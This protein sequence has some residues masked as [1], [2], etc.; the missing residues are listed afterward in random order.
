MRNGKEEPLALREDASLNA[1]GELNGSIEAPMVFVGYGLSIP[2]A[3]WDDLAGL[4]LRGKIAVYVNAPAPVDVS[5]NV[6]SHVNSADERWAAL[7]KAGAIG[8][9]TLP[10]PRPPAGDDSGCRSACAAAPRQDAAARR[11]RTRQ[12]SSPTAS[13]RSRPGR[14][15]RSRSPARGAEKFLAGSGHTIEEL[16]AAGRRQQAAAALCAGGHASGPGRA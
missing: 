13:F 4:D 1:R 11:L 6:K 7:K 16:D 5:D 8:I 15:S 14:P 12:S 10:D 3:S 9:A 2:E